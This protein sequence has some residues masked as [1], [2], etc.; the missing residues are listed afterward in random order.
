MNPLPGGCQNSC[1]VRPKVAYFW[2]TE[3][4]TLF[5]Q[6]LVNSRSGSGDAR[7]PALATFSTQ[8]TQSCL[9]VALKVAQPERDGA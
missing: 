8:A 9:G 3:L 6:L 7:L 4:H 1:L 2:Y 5:R